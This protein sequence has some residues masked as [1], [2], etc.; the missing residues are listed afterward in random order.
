[1]MWSSHK[2][3]GGRDV[4]AEENKPII[5]R[6]IEEGYNQDRL[7]LLD[8]LAAQ[9]FVNPPALPVQRHGIEGFK[10]V[11]WWTHA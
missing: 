8:E 3:S 7:N 6:L 1:M 10:H 4:F 5:R 9:D 11:L 2:R